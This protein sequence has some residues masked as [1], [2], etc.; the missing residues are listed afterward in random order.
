MRQ[1]D[2]SDFWANRQKVNGLSEL[3]KSPQW[4]DYMTPFLSATVE[5]L[6]TKLESVSDPAE[7]SDT[8]AM[9]RACKKLMTIGDQISAR[10]EA[11]Q[12]SATA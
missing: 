11:E 5:S 9:I 2:L 6:R 12:T 3:V 1:P 7:L 4:H 10:L 8:Q